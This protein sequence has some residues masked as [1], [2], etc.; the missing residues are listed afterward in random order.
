M[1]ELSVILSS[2]VIEKGED[3]EVA[4]KSEDCLWSVIFEAVA[5][6]E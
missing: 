6:S 3:C 2:S 1:T 4:Y 5:V